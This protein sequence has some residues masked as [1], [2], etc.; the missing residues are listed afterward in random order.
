MFTL[1][2]L[3]GCD[4]DGG[5]DAGPERDAGP[6]RDA[7]EATGDAGDPTGQDAGPAPIDAGEADAGPGDRVFSTDPADF[8]GPPRCGSLDALFC[9]DFEDDPVG[10]APDAPGWV[11]EAIGGGEVQ[12][13]DEDAGRGSR[14]LRIRTDNDFSRGWARQESIFPREQFYARVLFRVVA[15]GPQAFVHW[16][17]VEAIGRDAPGEPL[18]RMRIGGVSLRNDMNTDF[19]FNRFFFNFEMNPRPAGFDEFTQE[20]V[21]SPNLAWGDWHCVETFY[22]TPSDTVLMWYDGVERVRFERTAVGGSGDG[23]TADLPV[24]DGVN[25]GWTIY[26]SIDTP[27]T[28]Y[29]DEV[30]LDDER[31]GCGN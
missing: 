21:D 28:V 2:A 9:D 27:F 17:L 31:I 6:R 15:P 20:Q 1:L 4:D 30:A 5:G 11:I 13:T 22:D 24:F 26:Q 10:G 8:F 7:G 12:V 16:D 19:I 29:L 3:G 25:L 18:K 14:A 23:R